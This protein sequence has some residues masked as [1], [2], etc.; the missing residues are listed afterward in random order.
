MGYLRIFEVGGM[1]RAEKES[2]NIQEKD[3]D[4]L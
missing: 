3:N 4:S 2:L 1:E